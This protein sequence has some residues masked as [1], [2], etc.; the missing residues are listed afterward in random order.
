[1]YIPMPLSFVPLYVTEGWVEIRYGDDEYDVYEVNIYESWA[2]ND[3]GVDL[4]H[5]CNAAGEYNL[6]VTYANDDGYSKE[7]ARSVLKVVKNYS[8]DDFINQWKNEVSNSYN[9]IWKIEDDASSKLD[10]VV[11]IFDENGSVAYNKSFS[12]EETYEYITAD[13]LVGKFNGTCNFT[14]V[15]K[16]AA[17]G[18]DMSKNSTVNFLIAIVNILPVPED[19]NVVIT[20]DEIDINDET[21]R[22]SVL[23]GL[24]MWRNMIAE[25]TIIRQSWFM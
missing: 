11:T 13:N 6:T 19:F 18:K 14:V 25:A 9:S 1:M 5:L 21:T 23:T 12:G 10:G 7:L 2:G 15:Y 20:E 16:R 4:C 8:P 17:D 3:Y 22:S 24:I